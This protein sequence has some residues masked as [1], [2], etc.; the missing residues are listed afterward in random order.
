MRRTEWAER[1]RASP[2]PCRLRAIAVDSLHLYQKLEVLSRQG[3]PLYDNGQITV[4][5]LSDAER[6]QLG[7]RSP[8]SP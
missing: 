5:R 7:A 4:L 6:Q 8:Q 3:R 2:R 1:L